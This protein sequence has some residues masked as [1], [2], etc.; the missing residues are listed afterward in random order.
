MRDGAP[1]LGAGFESS[2]RGLHFVGAFAAASF[3]P[4]MR[5]VSGTPFTGVALGRHVAQRAPA[6]V[7]FAP[8]RPSA[9]GLRQMRPGAVVTGA[10]Y[11]ALAVV[12]SL[13]RRGV[14]VRVVRSDEHALAASSRYAQRRLGWPD[15]RSPGESSHLLELAER[16]GLRGWVLIPTHDEEAA[17]IARH[18]DELARQLSGDDTR[19]GGVA[20]RLRQA[21][22]ARARLTP[23]PRPAVDVFPG[24]E[25]AL[26]QAEG[27][28]PVVIKPAYKASANRLTV[29]KAWRAD[30]LDAASSAATRK[31]CTLV[32]PDILMV[33]QLVAGDGD[34][35]ALL[36]GALLRR[37]GGRRA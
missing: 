18:R 16:E 36:R 14:G 24:R 20:G 7:A 27:R 35:A 22:H 5:F 28:L 3:G 33:Q 8:G 12:R 9:A 23:G 10:S 32:D 6:G 34:A 30:D 13:G 26:E 21:H 25:G 31:A 29:D 4:V 11:R 1:L 2:I 19:L 15:A 37:R 17:L